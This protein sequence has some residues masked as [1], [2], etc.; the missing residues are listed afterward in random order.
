VTGI[1]GWARDAPD[2]AA[3]VST[4][5]V[6]SFAELDERHRALAG[7][8]KAMGSRPGD[9]IAI[10]SKNRPEVI[11]AA[12]GALRA[13]VIPVMVNAL[14]TEPEVDYILSDARVEL[15]LTDR[16]EDLGV[17]TIIT[18]G[19]AYER[20]LH[21][22]VP[23]D[24][25]DVTLSRPMFYTS[26]S[27]GTPK[28]VY[29]EPLAPE[30]AARASE[31]FLRMWDLNSDD[32]HLVCS[33]LAHSAP[34]RY[35]IRTLEAGGSV[36]VPPHFEAEQTLAAIDL[37]AVTSTFMVPTHLERILALGRSKIGGFDLSSIRLLCHAG[38]PI[39][40]ATKRA[41][42]DLF[43]RGSVWEFYG[44]TEGQA[45]RI[46]SEEWLRKPGS[47]GQPHPG[48]RVY[49]MSE[50]FEKMA[51]GAAGQIW[52]L[53]NDAEPWVY[54]GDPEKTEVAW[55]DGAFTAN[56]LGYLDTDGYLFLTGRAGDT[57]I[58]GGVNVYPQEVEAVLATHPE[59]AEVVVYG[60][61]NTEWGEEVRARIVLRAEAELD[62]PELR[63]WARERLASFKCPRVFEL[64][65]ELE[66]TATG[67]IKRPRE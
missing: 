9:R 21:E 15:L 22:A 2:A 55:R 24:I 13:G 67:K 8:L 32:V 57:I 6:V 48:A 4:G 14:L 12:A 50:D 46:S 64:V 58:T 36:V 44:S 35:S 60:A 62:A 34:L 33:P 19:A 51:P 30:Q 65:D 52:I 20:C 61:P 56:D 23:I 42:I 53:D 47:V 10:L 3:F 40:D 27:T 45:T 18:F 5:A 66:T 28:G 29:V 41:I 43:P 25:A 17:D 54:W 26:G 63:A 1:G 31:R 49:V 59:I 39:K 37:F 38:A 11:E 16:L 7:F